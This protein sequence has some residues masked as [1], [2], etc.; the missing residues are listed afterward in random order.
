MVKYP[1]AEC[2]RALLKISPSWLD[3]FFF[4][5]VF[6]VSLLCIYS[7]QCMESSM[8][9]PVAYDK[10]FEKMNFE[11]LFLTSTIC[12]LFYG[13]GVCDRSYCKCE[14]VGAC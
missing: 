9:S 8:Y 5:L 1:V 13:N 6:F 11:F 10:S 4:V 2:K 12:P 3:K 14:Y 7:P